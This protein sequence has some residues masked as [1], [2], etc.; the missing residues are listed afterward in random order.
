MEKKIAVL[1]A[2]AI[3]S[4]VGADLARA[5]YDVVLIDQW[6]AHVEA[7][8]AGGLRVV[9][10]DG[11][12]VFPERAVRRRASCRQ[13]L[14]QLLDGRIHQA[15]PQ[16]GRRG[17]FSAEQSERRVDRAHRRH[18][19]RHR[20]RHRTLRGNLH[21]RDGPAQHDPRKD[22]VRARRAARKDHP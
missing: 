20:L 18:H 22:M 15:V 10:P 19:A 14:R 2:G 21:S 8:K 12:S 4:S 13:V 9:M 3:G 5:G 1:G 7:M 17:G 11:G 16:A 6:P